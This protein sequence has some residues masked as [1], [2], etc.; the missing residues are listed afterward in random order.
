MS[1][2]DL[3]GLILASTLI[4]LDGTATNIALPAIGHDLS[5]PVS[6][7]QWIANAPLLILAAALLPAG[8][9]G[10]R[11]G[12]LRVLRTG[13]VL[14]VAASLVCCAAGSDTV[15]IIGKFGQGAGGALVL[16]TVLA[17]L[18][19]AYDDPVERTRIFGVWAAWTGMAGAAGPLLAGVLVDVVSWRSVFVMSI[20]LGI[21]ALMLLVN[22]SFE[23]LHRPSRAAPTAAA[24]FSC[25]VRTRNCRRANLTDFALYFGLFGVSF[26][27]ALY[28][29]QVLHYSATSAAAILLPLSAMLL[30]A[31]RFGRLTSSIGTRWVV[32]GGVIVAAAGAAWIGSAP[33][34]V[35]L[36]SHIILGNALVGLGVSLTVPALT[37]VAVAG[38]P[39]E[40]AG[41]ASGLNHAVVRAAGLFAIA[42]LGWVAAPGRSPLISADGFQHAML[43]CAAV[44]GL[45]GLAGSLRL[46]DD[47]PGGVESED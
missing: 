40:Y 44:V 17:V 42:L 5:A 39:E 36:W 3:A 29:Q 22:R 21:S 8:T 31:E 7:L 34:P 26:L 11:F 45:G 14:F 37:H 20:V 18:R 43:L 38:V 19:R 10:D 2:R 4:T 32:L 25:L 9:V 47:E 6:R 1:R 41:A 13:V 12:H 23:T 27:L 24:V 35:P 33:H 15:I 16:P 46:R 30:L 28:L